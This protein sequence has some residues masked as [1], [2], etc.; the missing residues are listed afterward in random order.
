MRKLILLIIAVSILSLLFIEMSNPLNDDV[1]TE[2]YPIFSLSEHEVQREYLKE[3][4]AEDLHEIEIG[5]SSIKDVNFAIA[6]LDVNGDK[7][8][9]I[10]TIISNP[11]FT[12]YQHNGLLT[13]FIAEKNDFTQIP[14]TEVTI[15]WDV[16]E[17]E[18]Q[19]HIKFVKGLKDMMDIDIDGVIWTWDNEKYD[20]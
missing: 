11:Y 15:E 2:I 17:L 1:E 4:F 19:K 7:Q 6:I 10:L 8:D 12:G 18:N 20:I 9:D 13:L 16:N 3:F 14:I 5:P